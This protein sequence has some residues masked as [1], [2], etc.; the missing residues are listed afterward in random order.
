MR[1][2][3]RDAWRLARPYWFSEDRWAG[4]GLLA[5]VV[6]LNLGQVYLNVLFNEW[7]KFFYDA[8]QDKNWDAFVHQMIRFSWL[9]AIFIV[10]GVYSLYFNQMLQIRW[11]RWMTERFLG[12]YLANQTYYRMQF[13]E[14]GADNPDQRIAD[15][16]REFV[17]SS[18]TLSLGLLSSVVTLFSFV[19]ILWEI[20]GPLTIPLGE[21]GITIPGYMV[22]VALLYAIVGTVIVARIGRPLVGINFNQQRYEADFRF[23][24][25]R[26]RENA[27]GV[28]LYR[29]EP[30]EQAQFDLR[31]GRVVHN[32]WELMKRRKLL[33]FF[34][35]GYGQIAIIFP[36][37]V[38]A[39]RYFSGAIQLGDLMQIASAFGQVQ[40][41]LSYFVDAFPQLAEWRAVADRLLGFQA[42]MDQA[43]AAAAQADV[44]RVPGAEG[45]LGVG[46]LDLLLPGG[47]VL[48][49]D[50]TLDFSAGS[51]TL[52]NGPSGSGKSTF[53]RA[54]AGIWPFGSGRVH[55]P[56]GA[57]VLFL[58][59]KAYLPVASLRAVL[60]YPAISGADDAA[61]R[62]VLA[63]VG[64][65]DLAGRLDEDRNW[66]LQ[67]SPGEQQRIAVA[68]ALLLKPDWLFLDE[69]TASVDEAIERNLYTLLRQR[70]PGCA[71]VSIGH[72]PA[73]VEFH[74]RVLHLTP[75]V[76][77]TEIKSGSAAP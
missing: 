24:L 55:V 73:L 37:F 22:W 6:G 36:Y 13:A 7:N 21:A 64:L 8:L 69:A 39:P 4:R 50:V 23:S 15:D 44:V 11:R 16:L 10:V 46:Q 77:I 33:N 41:A 43:D 48:A 67:L 19:F 58:P 17:A 63:D 74:H 71:I 1:A 75:G 42:A 76:G 60:L 61:L 59:Q 3:F 27:E 29:G 25:I 51:A 35:Y 47:G 5:L 65:P 26:F 49:R 57:K 40:N 12:R 68:R 20:S 34:A 28:A 38:A 53:F 18:L 30:A 52:L 70:L 32:W 45:S 66:A 54:I 62:A 31:F 14:H 56:A 9:A 72:R 2:F